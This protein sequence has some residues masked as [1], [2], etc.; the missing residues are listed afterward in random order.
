MYS[1]MMKKMHTLFCSLGACVNFTQVAYI[2]AE[3]DGFV[4]VCVELEGEIE[5]Y[6]T[7]YLFSIPG[8]AAGKLSQG[9]IQFDICERTLNTFF[10]TADL[11]FI[12]LR[13]ALTFHAS[14]VLCA[15]VTILMGDSAEDLE[16]FSVVLTT[17]DDRI[18]VKEY[19][20]PIYIRDSNSE[21]FSCHIDTTLTYFN[22]VMIRRSM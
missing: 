6:I 15:N 13:E 16:K 10:S 2:A 20:V 8:T 17:H 12:P 18:E 5:D 7:V 14:G 19:W 22:E 21:S 3:Q 9:D 4:E 11:D 1:E